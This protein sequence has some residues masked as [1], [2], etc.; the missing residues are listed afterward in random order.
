V[1]PAPCA[2][3]SL[4]PRP[5]DPCVAG[6][7]TSPPAGPGT[8]TTSARPTASARSPPP[9]DSGRAS[10][11]ASIDLRPPRREHG[12]PP[13]PQTASA[14]APTSP[15]RPEPHTPATPAPP[16]TRRKH[17]YTARRDHSLTEIQA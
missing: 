5:P 13:P 11:D 7:C 17:D 6:P 1:P 15:R 10:E 8:A 4:H 2:A 16:A 3:A 14:D 9:A 12:C